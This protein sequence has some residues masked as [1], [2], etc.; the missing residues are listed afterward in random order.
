MSD[1]TFHLKSDEQLLKMHQFSGIILGRAQGFRDSRE[2]AKSWVDWYV[3]YK[4]VSKMLADV[5]DDTISATDFHKL[6]GVD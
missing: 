4:H 1:R 3:A 2:Q 5:Q 6:W